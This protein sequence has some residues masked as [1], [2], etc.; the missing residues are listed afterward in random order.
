MCI[1]EYWGLSVML[2]LTTNVYG[3]WLLRNGLELANETGLV[4]DVGLLVRW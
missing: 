2:V 3:T 4:G 1:P